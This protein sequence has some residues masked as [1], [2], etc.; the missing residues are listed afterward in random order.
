MLRLAHH[1]VLSRLQDLLCVDVKLSI[2]EDEA[3]PV[4]NPIRIIDSDERVGKAPIP[5][6]SYC[7]GIS[8]HIFVLQCCAKTV[9]Y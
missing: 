4:I 2:G 5:H 9:F 7:G 8:G 1:L 6:G 3:L